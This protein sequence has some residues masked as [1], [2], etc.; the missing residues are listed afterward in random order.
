MMVPPLK[1]VREGSPLPKKKGSIGM[2][3]K[4]ILG[5]FA[6]SAVLVCSLGG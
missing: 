1:G 4:K 3:L 2:K 6:L 5:V